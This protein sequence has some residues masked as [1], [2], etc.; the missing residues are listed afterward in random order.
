MRF[1]ASYT[2]LALATVLLTGCANQQNLSA[3]TDDVCGT[4]DAL[5]AD[6]PTGFASFRGKADNFMAGTVYR[7]KVELIDG[8]CQIWSWGQGDSAYLCSVTHS[9]LDVA[10]TRH[11][12]A[13]ASVKNCLGNDWQEEGDWRQRDGATDGYAS[14]FRSPTT[15]AVV[16]VQTTAQTSGPGKRFTNFLYIGGEGRSNNL[17]Q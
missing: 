15:Q 12:R 2:G 11:E 1:P 13:L 10:K 3:G 6:Y 14:R 8:N 9:D 7:A 16:S 5:I 4:L 17:G